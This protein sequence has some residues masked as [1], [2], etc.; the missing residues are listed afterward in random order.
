ML[1]HK[2]WKVFLEAEPTSQCWPQKYLTLALLKKGILKKSRLQSECKQLL[3][4]LHPQRHRKQIKQFKGHKLALVE[5][6]PNVWACS[7]SQKER[8][9]LQN[10]CIF[11][12]KV[13]NAVCRSSGCHQE[14]ARVLPLVVCGHRAI[15]WAVRL[16]AVT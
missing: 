10:H 14:H 3:P 13:S 8:R 7:L 2:L 5:P 6:Q 4:A 9:R 16:S 11:T 12:C 1:D 15:G